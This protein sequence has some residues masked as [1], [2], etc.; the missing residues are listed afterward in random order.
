MSLYKETAR[1]MYRAEYRE[2]KREVRKSRRRWRRI[3]AANFGWDQMVSH[4]LW[5]IAYR[6][7]Y[8]LRRAIRRR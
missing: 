8:K 7:A 2:Y 1:E 6:A 4:P 3:V 5:Y